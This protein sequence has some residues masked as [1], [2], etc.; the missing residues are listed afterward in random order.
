MNRIPTN[1]AD[2]TEM[3]DTE[4]DALFGDIEEDAPCSVRI[5]YR[6]GAYL[7]DWASL[8]ADVAA[9]ETTPEDAA[10]WMN[11]KHGGRYTF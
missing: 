11:L 6:E 1:C 4:L 10:L 8:K 7:R 2:I 3:T 5:A 9:G